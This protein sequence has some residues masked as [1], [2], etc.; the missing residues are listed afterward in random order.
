MWW[1]PRLSDKQGRKL[2]LQLSSIICTLLYT[3]LLLTMNQTVLM[4]VIFLFGVTMPLQFTIG[5]IYLLEL[6][7]VES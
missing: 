4:L 2:V 6:M 5:F 1:I 7:P 3:I